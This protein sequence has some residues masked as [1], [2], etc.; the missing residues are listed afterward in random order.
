MKFHYLP[1]I[2]MS[3]RDVFSQK[4]LSLTIMWGDQRVSIQS[5]FI[6]SNFVVYRSSYFYS[7]IIHR[8][9][10]IL[11]AEQWNQKSSTWHPFYSVINTKIFKIWPLSLPQLWKL[12]LAAQMKDSST[13]EPNYRPLFYIIICINSKKS[14]TDMGNKVM[15]KKKKSHKY[16]LLAL[17]CKKLLFCLHSCCAPASYLDVWVKL[18]FI[19]HCIPDGEEY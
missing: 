8:C 10:Q 19:H 18:H 16:K 12:C 2:W 15:K 7:G 17:F 9:I 6:C 3:G 13:A 5:F 11:M 4:G 1:F 14:D